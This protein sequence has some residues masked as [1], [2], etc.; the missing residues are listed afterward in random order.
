MF[1]GSKLSSSFKWMEL[2]LLNKIKFLLLELPTD[3]RVW[4]R[5]PE[6]DLS[7]DFMFLCLMKVPED[8][9]L[10]ILFNRK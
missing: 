6:E 2:K 5:Q 4:T 8:Y 3:P 1:E 9:L 7:E 10:T